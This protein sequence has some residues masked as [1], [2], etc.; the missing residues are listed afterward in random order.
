MKLKIR[1]IGIALSMLSFFMIAT[2]CGERFQDSSSVV[3]TG[4]ILTETTKSTTSI[5]T[6]MSDEKLEVKQLVKEI[7]M[8]DDPCYT[9]E[10]AE[11][12]AEWM[13]DAA[14]PFSEIVLGSIDSEEEATEKGRT[15]LI[16]LAG[17]EFVDNIESDLFNHDG[18]QLNLQRDNPPYYVNYYEKYDA[19][20]VK[21]ILRSGKL[22]SGGYI[23]TPGEPPYVILRGR[24]GKVIAVN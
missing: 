4:S 10:H 21:A 17:Q 1:N 20:I 2:A 23:A 7:L 18:E 22:E 16:K 19:W 9:E 13:V 5:V 8:I 11:E 6:T 12:D 24:D 14:E 3:S 15:V